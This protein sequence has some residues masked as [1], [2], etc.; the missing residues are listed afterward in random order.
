M[1]KIRLVA[2][3]KETEKA[4]EILR[5]AK[6]L[7]ILEVSGFYENRNGSLLG[8]TYVEADIKEVD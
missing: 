2:T 4:V 1:L 6:E 3:Q 5:K 7:Q 8:R